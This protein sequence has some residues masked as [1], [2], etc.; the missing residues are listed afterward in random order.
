MIPLAGEKYVVELMDAGGAKKVYPFPEVQPVGMVMQLRDSGNFVSVTVR[1]TDN[2]A[3]HV[4]L[5]A[6]ARHIITSAQLQ[7]LQD[8]R[9]R[10]LLR[11]SDLPGG[12]SHI[13]IF[14]ND[15]RPVCERLYFT[16]PQKKLDLSVA[17]SQSIFSTRQRVSVTVQPRS[18]SGRANLSMSVHKVDSGSISGPLGIYPYL[19]LSSDLTGSI[20]SP[21]YYVNN[22]SAGRDAMVDNLMLTHGWRRFAWTDVLSNPEAPEF[23]PEVREHI[24]TGVVSKDGQPQAAVFTYLGSPGKIVRAYG[25]WSNKLGEVRFEIKDFYGP[26]RII[27]QTKSDSSETYDITIA[28]PFSRQWHRERLPPLVLSPKLRDELLMRSIAMQ[29][30]DIYY[31]DLADDVTDPGIDSSAFYGKADATYF[32]DDYTRFPLMEEVMREYVPGVFVRKRKDG[33]HFIVVDHANGGVLPG[34]PMVLLD[35]VPVPDVDDIMR[36]DPLL[37]KKLEVVKRPYYLGQAVFSGIVSYTTYLGDLGGLELDPRSV[38]IDYNG[39]QLQREFH[40]PQHAPKNVRDRM[41][42][43]R[44]LLHWEPHIE[45]G[46]NG[47]SVI[48]FYTSDVPGR[49]AIITEGIDEHGNSGTSTR[50][51][52]VQAPGDE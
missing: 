31:E 37:V 51:F 26:R 36:V 25:A 11:K 17:T 50:F 4:Y 2:I 15:F 41:P 9:A 6:H 24:V 14:N 5:F 1:S 45:I 23:L 32:L 28:D 16:A 43:Q 19:W 3:G 52:T 46:V 39:L 18:A 47:K 12:I 7:S 22:E 27:L 35:G 8:R 10:F 33:F 42:D 20:E 38:S 34:D 49:Y 44:Y 29:V 48:E 30:Q 40:S 21:E 13:T